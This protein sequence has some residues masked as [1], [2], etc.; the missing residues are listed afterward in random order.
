MGDV[1][2]S[3]DEEVGRSPNIP[4]VGDTNSVYPEGSGWVISGL[5]QKISIVGANL[6]V[7]W[8]GGRSIAQTT[9]KELIDQNSKVPFTRDR[10]GSFF[11]NWE[12]EV[13]DQA[14]AFVD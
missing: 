13:K 12:K 3:G 8:A 2:L 14:V 6:L 7:G 1:L 4:T 10:L 5:K 11:K 9:I